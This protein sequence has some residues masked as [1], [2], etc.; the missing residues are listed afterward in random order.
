MIQFTKFLLKFCGLLPIYTNRKL[1]LHRFYETIKQMVFVCCPVYT[2]FTLLAFGFTTLDDLSQSTI[3]MYQGIG[4]MMGDLMHLA[5]FAQSYE[6]HD[7]FQAID[8]LAKKRMF[9]FSQNFKKLLEFFFFFELTKIG[10]AI[11]RDFGKFYIEADTVTT[12][13]TKITFKFW[14]ATMIT[15]SSR[16]YAAAFRDYL[17]GTYSYSSWKLLYEN[18]L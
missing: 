18:S 13:W 8:T 14:A 12:K 11:N 17:F 15:M 5:I 2:T 4:F 10:M 7:V 1:F 6:L 16:P 3:A 9:N